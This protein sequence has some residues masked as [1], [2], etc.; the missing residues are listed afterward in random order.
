MEPEVLAE[1]FTEA[2]Q[3]IDELD[4]A[5]Y[6]R[7]RGIFEVN[8]ELDRTLVSFQANKTEPYYRWYKYKEAFSSSLVKYLLQSYRVPLG[9]VFDPFAGIGTA[10]F[11]A[12]ELGY[13]SEGIELLPIGQQII[14]SRYSASK[15]RDDSVIARLE[16]WRRNLPWESVE[17]FEAINVLRITSGAY[18][19][20]TETSV[21]KFL[22][23]L[24]LEEPIAQKLLLTALFCVLEQVSYT[25]K[26]G[27]YLRWDYRSGRL[28]G[29]NKFDKGKIYPF[30][31]AI[32]L[33]L[34]QIIS[35]LSNL[36]VQGDFLSGNG[37]PSG[38]LELHCG[39]SLDLLPTLAS[40]RF[41]SI[42]TSPPY[43]NRYDYTRT[44]ALE[45]ALMGISESQILALRQ[46]MLSCTV[47]NKQKSLLSFNPNWQISIDICD[48]LD[49]LQAILNYLEEEKNKG[50]LNN[51]GIPRMVRGYFY[52]LACVL[53][54]CARVLKPGGYMFMVN[55]NVRY[56]GAAISVDLILS[57]IAEELGF[58]IEKIQVLPLDKGNSSQQMGIH[59]RRSLRKCVYA[60]RKN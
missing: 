37:H 3:E 51:T 55:D 7:F 24:Q 9:I 25:R 42:I 12:L 57:A 54:E 58:V 26:D 44:Y 6:D 50:T 15:L 35:D 45:L 40:N 4:D 2:L 22:T 49:L 56:A 29:Q 13:S 47:E 38:H 32:L 43:C 21:M 23:A 39:S 16:H 46:S 33:K 59:G 10:L 5:L 14:T 27:Q 36:N 53:Q 19:P 30:N 48:N 17:V 60:W 34:D 41:T 8:R 31:Q 11:S 20:N 52:E 1:G 18:P 28:N